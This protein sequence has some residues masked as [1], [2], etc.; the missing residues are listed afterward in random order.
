MGSLV[1]PVGITAKCYSDN[2]TL[3]KTLV[4][5]TSSKVNLLLFLNMI[6]VISYQI[7]NMIIS[8]FFGELKIIE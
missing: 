3:I 7:V 1:A 2:Q 8:V 5:L 4:A 6:L